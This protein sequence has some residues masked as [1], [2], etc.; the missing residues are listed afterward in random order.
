M[1][2]MNSQK[3]TLLVLVVDLSNLKQKVRSHYFTICLT[4]SITSKH[5]WWQ[6]TWNAWIA[7]ILHSQTQS[8][9][10]NGSNETECDNPRQYPIHGTDLNSSR[11]WIFRAVKMGAPRQY[12]HFSDTEAAEQSGCGERV[13]T[14]S[15]CN[16]STLPLFCRVSRR[17]APEQTAGS[18]LLHSDPMCPLGPL[19]LRLKENIYKMS[20][21]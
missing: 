1:S 11:W 8:W 9:V 15:P 5:K 18:S 4:Q 17:T 14:G 7:C 20:P 10:T 16:I 12:S 21:F 19:L 3:D 2:D 13:L 6:F